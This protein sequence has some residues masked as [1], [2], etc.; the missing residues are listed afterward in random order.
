M[1]SKTCKCTV[2][3]KEEDD[4]YLCVCGN[5]HFKKYEIAAES[6]VLK[7]ADYPNTAMAIKIKALITADMAELMAMRDDRIAWPTILKA[8]RYKFA[9]TTLGRYFREILE[10]KYPEKKYDRAIQ[11]K[12]PDVIKK[13]YKQVCYS[14]HASAVR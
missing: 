4:Y 8:K 2:M 3:L 9:P 7:R 13:N 6:P 5:I 1:A 14:G 10:E 11:Y 12:N